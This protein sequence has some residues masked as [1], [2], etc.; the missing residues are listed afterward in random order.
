MERHAAQR[1]GGVADGVAGRWRFRVGPVPVVVQ[2]V[3]VGRLAPL[4]VSAAVIGVLV[5][6]E[7]PSWLVS[8]AGYAAVG[9]LL[10]TLGGWVPHEAAHALAAR[11]RGVGPTALVVSRSLGVE[12]PEAFWS[13]PRRARA[14]V[15]LAGPA[16]DLGV[17]LLLCGGA[18][19]AATRGSV[20]VGALLVGVA[21]YVAPAMAA[22][23][24]PLPDM[25]MHKLTARPRR[26]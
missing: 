13:W 14:P 7:A 21:V 2:T 25:D 18:W 15:L 10:G 17:L 20:E 26:A 16:A 1:R 3:P 4:A 8:G 23:L 11:S 19:L 6:V 12:L 5:A 22:S 24:L 9:V